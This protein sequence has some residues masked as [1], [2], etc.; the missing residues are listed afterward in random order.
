[1]FENL[2]QWGGVTLEQFSGA[3]FNPFFPNLLVVAYAEGRIPSRENLRSVEGVGEV[4]TLPQS[5][6]EHLVFDRDK[7]KVIKWDPLFWR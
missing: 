7:T 5:M 6:K 2:N 3:S 1:M 4:I